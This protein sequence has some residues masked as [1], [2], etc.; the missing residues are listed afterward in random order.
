[1]KNFL[2]M[3]MVVMT[4]V[5][6]VSVNFA[7]GDENGGPGIGMSASTYD[8]SSGSRIYGYGTLNGITGAA[9]DESNGGTGV[10]PTTVENNILNPIDNSLINMGPTSA[11]NN[12]YSIHSIND[13]GPGTGV[14]TNELG[15]PTY[16]NAGG[17]GANIITT[18]NDG[19]PTVTISTVD[20]SNYVTEQNKKPGDYTFAG[21]TATDK[22]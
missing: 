9:V 20:P 14:T 7:E 15:N 8:G 22:K 17:P 5:A 10:A 12:N 4:I 1:M 18:T 13:G 21:G 2:R 3:S 11:N 6:L 19:S 16:Y